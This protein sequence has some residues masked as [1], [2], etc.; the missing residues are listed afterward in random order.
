MR[1]FTVGFGQAVNRPLLAHLARDKRG[2][3][4]YI[5]AAAD[6]EKEVSRSTARLTRPCS[7]TSRSTRRA[8]R[9]RV[10]PPTLPDLFLDDELRINGRLR[11]SGPVVFTLKGK[12]GGQASSHQVKVDGRRSSAA[13]GSARLWAAARVD[14]LAQEIALTGTGPSSGPR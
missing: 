6:I 9:H 7:S 4:K 2:R 13:P 3:F 12:A 11:A 8:A 10:Y 1:V 14:D 5:P